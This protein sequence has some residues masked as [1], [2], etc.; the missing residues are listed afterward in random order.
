M[1]LFAVSHWE[2]T[3]ASR[4]AA[5]VKAQ[6]AY[7]AKAAEALAAIQADLEE[8]AVSSITFTQSKNITSLTVC[9]C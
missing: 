7:H 9:T 4:F 6:Q 5:L 8:S 3:D 2:V 1:S